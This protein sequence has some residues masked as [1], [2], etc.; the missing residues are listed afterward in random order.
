MIMQPYPI[1][2]RLDWTPEPALIIGWETHEGG[3]RPAVAVAM[4]DAGTVVYHVGADERWSI[5]QADET[6]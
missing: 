3:M 6:P 2:I 1:L 5:V 4:G